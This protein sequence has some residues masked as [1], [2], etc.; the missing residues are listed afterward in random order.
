M[1]IGS[2]ETTSLGR[3]LL[4]L[5]SILML[6]PLKIIII[7]HSYLSSQAG[8]DPGFGKRGIPVIYRN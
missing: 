3:I 1:P 4:I 5:W 7:E 2:M 6:K 8:A